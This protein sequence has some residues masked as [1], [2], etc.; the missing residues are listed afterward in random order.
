MLS[1]ASGHPV[2]AGIP[3]REIPRRDP[4]NYCDE[5]QDRNPETGLGRLRSYLQPVPPSYSE[6]RGG[7]RPTIIGRHPAAFVSAA[8]CLPPHLKNISKQYENRPS[9]Q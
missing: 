5:L 9:P 3:C 7:V 1:A 2:T 4:K 6:A 8:G